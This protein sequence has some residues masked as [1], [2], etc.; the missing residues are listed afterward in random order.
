[1][2]RVSLLVLFILPVVLL[3]GC[4]GGGGTSP[5]APVVGG[6][7]ATGSMSLDLVTAPGD[8]MERGNPL[9]HDGFVAPSAISVAVAK[10]E[11][12]Q[13]EDDAD[14]YVVFDTGADLTQARVIDLLQ[15]GASDSFGENDEYPEAGTYTHVRI[16]VVYIDNVMAVD[17]GDGQGSVDHHTR[18]YASTVGEIRDGDTLMDVNGRLCWI[19][20]AT[21]PPITGSR[22]AD[23]DINGSE[24]VNFPPWASDDADTSPDPLTITVALPAGQEVVV[25][26]NPT[27]TYLVN[28]N[29]DV[30]QSDIYPEATGIIFFDD[31]DQDGLFEPAVRFADGGDNMHGE[32][33][34]DALWEPLSP[35]ITATFT[36]QN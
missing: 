14:P 19:Q 24:V 22:P 13:G 25:P 31:T 26:A 6:V 15:A 35:K 1:M 11:L 30:T 18:I 4:G 29:F 34:G 27:G 33:T 2:A 7:Q 3:A 10:L 9:Y 36:K 12:L 8:G 32:A 16:T 28:V 23:P 5:I 17:I 21:F 20:G